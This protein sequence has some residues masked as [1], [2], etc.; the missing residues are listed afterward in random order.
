MTRHAARPVAAFL[1][2]AALAATLAG[3]D[4]SSDPRPSA[5]PDELGVAVVQNGKGGKQLTRGRVS[6]KSG[7]ILILEPD[8]S[9]TEVSLDSP[10]GRDAFERDEAA[11]KQA[12]EEFAETMRR[13]RGSE[14]RGK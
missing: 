7:D 10:A 12:A 14:A 5:K 4:R 1:A 8:G 11:Q 13:E 3:C 9:V 2:F 6:T